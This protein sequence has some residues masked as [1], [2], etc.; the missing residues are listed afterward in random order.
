MGHRART[1]S[2]LPLRSPDAGT[3]KGDNERK[4]DNETEMKKNSREKTSLL[5]VWVP[6]SRDS[7]QAAPGRAGQDP[8]LAFSSGTEGDC[9]A[10]ELAVGSRVFSLAFQFCPTE[11]CPG[12]PR[13]PC[14]AGWLVVA[15]HSGISWPEA[16]EVCFVLMVQIHQNSSLFTS[17]LALHKCHRVDIFVSQHNFCPTQDR[18]G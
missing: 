7:P 18:P 13:P 9:Q 3:R 12:P 5:S 10:E 8:G 11:P 2:P 6:G 15:N 16:A 4:S 1:F 17:L 14:Q